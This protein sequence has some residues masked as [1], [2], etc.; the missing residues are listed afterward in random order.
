[1]LLGNI[2]L[3]TP[4][5][6]PLRVA[7][8]LAV[9]LLPGL[10]WARWLFPTTSPLIRWTVG[11][12][13]SFALAMTAGLALSYL[14]GAISLWAELAVLDGLALIPVLGITRP[15]G[16]ARPGFAA[17]T[18]VPQGQAGSATRLRLRR[19]CRRTGG[20][21]RLEIRGWGAGARELAAKY[22][23]LALI[24]LVG[25]FFRLADLGYS[26]FQGDEALAM[27]SAAETLEG[28]SDALFLR[29]KGPGEVLLPMAL[30]RLTGT[31]NELIARLPFAV[32][33]LLMV[34]TVYL[35]GRRLWSERA[36]LIAAGLLALNGFMVGFSRIV[37]YQALVVWMSALALLCV[38]EAR[39]DGRARWAALAGICLGA[40]LLAHYD[41]VL[42]VPALAYLQISNL[43]SQ[44]SNVKL[45]VSRQQSAV[46]SPISN[47]QP[48]A[49]N[50]QSLISNLQSPT[51]GLAALLAVSGLFYI[52]YLLNPQAARTGGYL[53]ERIGDALLKNNLGSFLHFNVFYNSTYYVVLTGLL[54]LGYLAWLLRSTLWVRSAPGVCSIPGGRTWVP[55]LAV[56][57]ALGL[58]VWPN[59]L[60]FSDWDLA[61]LPFALI[62]LG[63]FLSPAL[64][65]GQRAVVAW[66]AIPFL[67][68]NFA[69][70]RPLTH[71]YTAV[72]AWTLLAAVPLANIKTQV[73]NFKS[74]ISNL[75]SQTPNVKRLISILQ[76]LISNLQFP[77]L[78]AA[79]LL[80]AALFGGYLY[81]AYLRHDVEFWQDWP[82]SQPA[83]YWSP[84]D[85]TPP[86]GFFGFA[87]R[88]GWKAV[89]ALYAAGQLSGDYGS[90]EEPDVT[91]WYT[92]GA[93]RA[94][95]P[96][97]E[98]YFIA[99]D[100]VDR[101]PV[102]LTK[103]KA[104]YDSIG[105]AALPNG[106]GLAFY[107]ARPSTTGLGSIE[108]GSLAGNFDSTA[109]PSAF[110]RSARGSQ[111]ADANLGG[112]VRLVGY[113]VDTRRAGPGGRVAVTLYWQVQAPIPADY[114]VF[115]HLE[116]DGT[117]A[118]PAGIWGQADG[119]PVCWTYPTFDWRPGQII[120]DQHA[121]TLKA[122]TPPGDYPI[123]VGMYRP[124]TGLRLDVLDEAGQP[125]ANFVKLAMVTIR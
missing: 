30:W 87:H 13:L 60:R 37:Q 105:R 106:K 21:W 90:N 38:W 74:Q 96:Q 70:A 86:A 124:D 33:G 92:R 4:A 110:A 20:E 95:D 59:A 122:D 67:G 109:T 65:P 8:G 66:L 116:G 40:G 55:A 23:P 22:W 61:V 56:I 75:K 50:L 64:D 27:I 62:L 35:L 58:A 88:T 77:L 120:A 41:A 53:G 19:R 113:D 14:P 57:V 107:Q 73:P 80:L 7:G 63:A 9:L 39:A 68:Y 46:Q 34:L 42:V 2:L 94:C 49:S 114:H 24:L 26:E 11:A 83:L 32:A 3:L 115:V 102:D 25:T 111:L 44:I 71:I 36:G 97:P 51:I 1:M 117:A 121:I 123:L 72:P 47:L 69:V 84:Y 16:P 5:G 10:A 18:G 125:V 28:H 100:L 54:V 85:Q 93:P 29:G 31:A 104:S 118:S 99:D 101:V 76:S 17:R 43:K 89:G 48:P 119:R 81:I 82:K 103:I 12:G 98:Y 6:S 78:A 108:P 45:T 112:L 52:P 91:T 15:P 79:C